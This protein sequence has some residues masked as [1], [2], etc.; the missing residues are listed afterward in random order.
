MFT[1][2]QEMTAREIGAAHSALSHLLAARDDWFDGTI[3]S[4]DRRLHAL[5]TA[6]P[7]VKRVAMQDARMLE[8]TRIVSNEI[9][10]LQVFKRDLLSRGPVRTLPKVSSVGRLSPRGRAFISRHLREFIADNLDALDDSEE[11][12]QRAENFAEIKTMQ[13]PVTEARSVVAHFRLAV[14]W[15]ARNAHRPRPLVERTSSVSDVPDS[16]LFD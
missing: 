1:S 7:S 13:L 15:N 2:K 10:Q 3:A 8:Q 6:L 5:R 16:A 4:V 11:L 12:D 14:D 9:E